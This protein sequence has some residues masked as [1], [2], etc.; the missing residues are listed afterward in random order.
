MRRLGKALAVGLPIALVSVAAW[1]G[2]HNAGRVSLALTARGSSVSASKAP[3]AHC[4]PAPLRAA[5]PARTPEPGAVSRSGPGKSKACLHRHRCA[6]VS[7]TFDD[8]DEDQYTNAFPVLQKY[9]IHGTF[10]IVTGFTGFNTGNMCLSQLQSL[11]QAGNEIGGHTVLHPDLTLVSTA[12][13]AREM[14]DG[15]NTLLKWGFPVTDFAYPYAA[16]NSAL[17]GIARQCGFNSARGLGQLRTPYGCQGCAPAESVPPADPYDFS[18]PGAV[19]DQWTLADLESVVTRA[20][21][22]GGW[23]PITF[24]HICSNDC[25]PYSV[26]PSLFGSFIKWLSTQPVSVEKV[27]QVIGGPVQAARSAPKV[28]VAPPHTNGVANPSL[29]TAGAAPPPVRG[30][31]VSVGGIVPYCFTRDITGTSSTTFTETTSDAHTGFVAE[32][33]TV[34][35]YSSGHARLITTQDLGQCAPEAVAGDRYSASAWYRSTVPAQLVFWY[36]DTIG[37]WHYWAVS[38]Q[39]PASS[40][41]TR[42]TWD[43]PAV[44]PGATALS[45]G[46]QIGAVGTLTTDDYFLAR[47]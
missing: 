3:A 4:R 21:G 29:E 26:S 47:Q 22:T 39:F 46:L 17:E 13:A 28:P 14:C 30:S 25:D 42:A 7:L 11:Y 32:T 16:V 5:L 37:G 6:V 34:S 43:T 36:R 45:F 1:T 41:W 9:G 35:A 19:I 38:P 2:Y 20:E 12:E 31:G 27:N 44:P 15:R 40:G 10:Y 33:V 23:V 18:A 8:G 24:H